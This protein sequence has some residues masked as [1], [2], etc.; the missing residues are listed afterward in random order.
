MA[1]INLSYLLPALL[2][3]GTGKSG[4]RLLAADLAFGRLVVLDVHGGR[5][6]P[7]SLLQVVPVL[8]GLFGPEG[9]IGSPMK[10]CPCLIV[11]PLALCILND[12]IGV[13][14]LLGMGFLKQALF[15][16][17]GNVSLR[18]GTRPKVAV[19]YIFKVFRNGILVVA[20]HADFLLGPVRVIAVLE[21]EDKTLDAAAE[22]QCHT[23]LDNKMG[24][25]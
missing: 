13:L 22:C 9:G 11:A 18:L 19:V 14:S 7:L 23:C 17:A 16:L 21:D 5:D 6:R 15:V 24:E 2:G 3:L 1:A 8:L 10:I 12:L 4:D 25:W 20:V